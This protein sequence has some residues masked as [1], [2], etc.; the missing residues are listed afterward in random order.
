[1]RI[2]DAWAL[3]KRAGLL[4]AVLIGLFFRIQTVSAQYG[5]DE[6]CGVGIE[7]IKAWHLNDCK[8]DFGSRVDRHEH[9]GKGKLGKAAFKNIVNDPRWRDLPGVLETPKGEDMKEDV[10]NLKVLRSL[11]N[12]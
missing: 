1:M 4:V 12:E 8:S 3:I 6:E 5:V 7:H 10:A 2:T 9:I 11:V